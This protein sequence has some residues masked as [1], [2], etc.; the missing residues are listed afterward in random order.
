MGVGAI[1]YIGDTIKTGS[2]GHIEMRMLDQATITL[3]GNSEFK[4][5]DH[6]F[7]REKGIGKVVMSIAARTFKAISGGILSLQ[8]SSFALN[9]P[10]ATIGIRGTE[11][12]GGP[13]NGVYEI[14]L[15]KGKVIIIENTGGRVKITQPGFGTRVIGPNVAPTAPVQWAPAKLQRA[16]D[17]VS[18]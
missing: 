11:L 6:L 7:D 2:N 1:V 8:K 4:I 14:A 18:F 5:E 3:G 17:T 16:I 15:L 13:I 9:S 12:W 10:V